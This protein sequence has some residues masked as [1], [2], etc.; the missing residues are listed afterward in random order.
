M[1]GGWRTYGIFEH[2]DE[3]LF[4]ERVLRL[5]CVQLNMYSTQRY[6]IKSKYEEYRILKFKFYGLSRGIEHTMLLLI[7]NNMDL[8]SNI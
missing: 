6:V 8:D 1:N 3:R 5:Y 7:H 2:S 4:N